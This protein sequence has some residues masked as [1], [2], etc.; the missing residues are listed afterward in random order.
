M[1]TEYSLRYSDGV[2]NN[3]KDLWDYTAKEFLDSDK[4]SSEL[5]G[6]T[7]KFL[8][9]LLKPKRIFEIGSYSGF[10]A[11]AWYEGTIDTQA[12]IITS[13]IE[14]RMIETTKRAISKYGM[15][16]RVTL[17][18]GAAQDT[19]KTLSGTFDIIFVDADKEGYEG[20]VKTAL[21]RKLLAKD[22][23]MLCDN[24]FSRGLAIS[25]QAGKDYLRKDMIPYWIECGKKMQHL[26]EFCKNDS[27][28][29]NLVLPLY[30]GISLI[31]WKT[32]VEV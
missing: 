4:M 27:R 20:Y 12:E 11:L 25:Q 1:A 16:D 13:E 3:M 18:E 7:N 26:N 31:K 5:Q 8:A 32:G 29:D 28:I 22:G 24:V 17:L 10:S 21:D 23:V 19:M 30:D 2:S 6:T 9:Q 14:P 15:Q